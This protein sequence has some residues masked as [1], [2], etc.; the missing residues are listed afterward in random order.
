LSGNFEFHKK[1]NFDQKIFGVEN[2][3]TSLKYEKDATVCKYLLHA[4]L[5]GKGW[6]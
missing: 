2:N 3:L 1:F 4:S 5:V 6:E